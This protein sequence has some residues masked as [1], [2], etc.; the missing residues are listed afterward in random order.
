[1]AAGQWNVCVFVSDCRCVC[2]SVQVR[3]EERKREME[4]EKA[5]VQ[6]EAFFQDKT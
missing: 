3:A 2:V 5:P 1:M 6:Q 4:I